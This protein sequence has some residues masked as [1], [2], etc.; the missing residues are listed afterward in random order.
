[1]AYQKIASDARCKANSVD[2]LRKGIDS[3]RQE[4]RDSDEK[5]CLEKAI[6]HRTNFGYIHRALIDNEQLQ[7]I[8][9]DQVMA[10]LYHEHV[11]NDIL[12]IDATG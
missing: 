9:M 2:A 6:T 11:R 3:L 7:I 10:A 8:L 1:M 4:L 5:E 12:H